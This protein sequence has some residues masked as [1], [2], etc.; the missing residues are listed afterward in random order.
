[1]ISCCI[2]VLR[3]HEKRQRESAGISATLMFGGKKA[4]RNENVAATSLNLRLYLG[5]HI[6]CI[7]DFM[8]FV[9]IMI[10]HVEVVPVL[11]FVFV[12]VFA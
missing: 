6:I 4:M 7:C 12:I 11:Y 8:I 9:S 2:I 1:M 10:V 3:C 5:F